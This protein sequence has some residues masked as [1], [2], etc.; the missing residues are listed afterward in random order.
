MNEPSPATELYQVIALASNPLD[1]IRHREVIPSGGSRRWT[2]LTRCDEAVEEETR[3]QTGLAHAADER[4]VEEL[5]NL[6]FRAAL[7]TDITDLE[8]FHNCR[9]RLVA[10]GGGC[11]RTCGRQE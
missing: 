6:D 3:L 1:R 5:A 9:C 2:H 4:A 8:R 7:R 11:R 10:S